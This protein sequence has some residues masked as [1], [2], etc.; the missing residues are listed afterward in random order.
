MSLDSALVGLKRDVGDGWARVARGSARGEAVLLP[1]GSLG[2]A[3]EPFPEMNWGDVYGP[4]AVDAFRAFVGR[5]RERGLPGV[6]SAMPDVAGEVGLA[7]LELGLH[8]DGESAPFMVCPR[9]DARLAEVRHE[10]TQVTDPRDLVILGDVIGDAF[11]CSAEWCRNML[12]PGFASTPD[13]EVFAARVDGEIAGVLCTVQVG[14]TVGVYAVATRRAV[15]RRGVG[16][17]ALSFAM[18]RHLERGAEAFGHHASEA[19]VT[20]YESLGF[21]AAL[22][23]PVWPV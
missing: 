19:G 17:S 12:G 22:A 1:G 6:I 20:L 3:G 4:G 9:E 5:L 23:V 8:G 10:V 14:S 7:A 18:G 2:I 16:A 13:L 11:D 15:Q 21:S